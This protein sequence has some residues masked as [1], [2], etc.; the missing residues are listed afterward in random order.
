MSFELDPVEVG[1]RIRQEREKRGLT[2]EELGKRSLCN[3]STISKIENGKISNILPSLEQIADSL[4]V[5][6]EY[7]L[8]VDSAIDEDVKFVHAFIK[9]FERITT[10]NAY[11]PLDSGAY[12]P[13]DLEKVCIGGKYLILEGNESI[14]E[15]IQDLAEIDRLKDDLTKQ[16]AKKRR[17]QAQT[18]YKR[19]IKSSQKE[20]YFLLTASQ[21]DEIVKEEIKRSKELEKIIPSPAKS[22]KLNKK[23]DKK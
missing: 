4:G 2:Q 16:E 15:L 6:K 9:R 20:T 14:F 7:L 8:G 23:S 3:K 12:A 11:Y 22:I 18:N 13:E 1:K 21:L 19:N 10:T 5:R 17:Q